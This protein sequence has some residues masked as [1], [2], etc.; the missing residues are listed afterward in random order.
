MSK[1]PAIL[2]R[3]QSDYPQKRAPWG[4]WA[5]IASD[6]GVTRKYISLVAKANGFSLISPDHCRAGHPKSVRWYVS[7]S[8]EGYC[9]ECKAIAVRNFR[10]R[11]KEAATDDR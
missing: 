8:G 10:T 7:Q 11:H 9:R 1:V 5:P 4:S 2:A 6:L 3:L